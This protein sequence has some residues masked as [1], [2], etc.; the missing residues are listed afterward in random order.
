[1]F[2]RLKKILYGERKGKFAKDMTF[3]TILKEECST[4]Y[5]NVVKQQESLLQDF[6]GS[7]QSRKQL[8]HKFANILQ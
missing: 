1:M 2:G 3:R 5:M 4:S 8:V 6:K 7:Q